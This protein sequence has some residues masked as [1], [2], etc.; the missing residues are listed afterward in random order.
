MMVLRDILNVLQAKTIH[1][2]DQKV[3]DKEYTHVS[4]A[5]LMSDALSM[6]CSSGTTTF[7]LTGLVNAQSIRTAEMLDIDTIVYVRNK[8]PQDVDLHIGM[9]INMN[10]FSTALS[11]YEACGLLYETGIKTATK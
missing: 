7:L 9:D 6:V 5:D 3:L 11:M 2:C 10:L 8:M 4:V 1:I